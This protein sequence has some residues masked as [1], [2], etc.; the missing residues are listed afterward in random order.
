MH[1]TERSREELL[2]ALLDIAGDLTMIRDVETML[3][4]IVRRTRQLLS[5]DMAYISLTDFENRET[6]IRQAD[7]V[8]TPAYR[9]L[10]QPL[11][12]GV[13]GQV[14]LGLAAY[15]TSDYLSDRTLNRLSD[16]DEIVRREGVR[17]IMGVPLRVGGR[18]MGALVVA[19]RSAREFSPDEVDLVDSIGKQAAVALD[20]SMR[21]ERLS[22]FSESLAGQQKRSAAE[23]A[24]MNRVLDLDARLMD[25]VMVEPDIRHIL[26]I[27]RGVLG[28]D[29]RFTDP[30]GA[31]I[32]TS[33]ENRIASR[34]A[35]DVA[36]ELASLA[37]PD[38]VPVLAAGQHLGQLIA[39]RT[40]DET[41]RGLLERV[42][43]HVALA[44]LF[45]RAE[46]DADL[47]RQSAFLEELFEGN[48]RALDRAEMRLQRWGIFPGDALWC[49]NVA[50]PAQE[51]RA[52]LHEFQTLDPGTVMMFHD[53]HM[54]MVTAVPDWEIRLRSLFAR[55]GWRLQAGV[56]GPVNRHQ[57]LPDAHRAAGFALGSLLELDRDGVADGDELGVLGAVL[58][59]ARRNALPGRLT[60]AIDPLLAYDAER[61]TD[62]ART[63]FLYLETDG[64]VARTG[65]LLVIHRNTVRQRIERIGTLLGPGWDRSPR[66]LDVHLALRAHDARV[67]LRTR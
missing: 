55:R 16:I 40:L 22:E 67:G 60:A 61:G 53:D 12:T 35:P 5:S 45:L 57:D 44:I 24:L 37:A 1:T 51:F 63:A 8:T 47:R 36:P 10:V 13:L 20:N 48:T 6:N 59:L 11:G 62:L 30:Y 38:S 49:V 18:V 50:T 29:L 27:G 2:A 14:A 65:G 46:K 56:S 54:C 26:D 25:A 21:F 7:G 9:T 34:R 3:Q 43:V 4:T 33:S 66:R 32:E 42:A 28:C 15:Q 64:N 31:V 39:S 41:D 19:E 58:D 23:V 17:A 52:H